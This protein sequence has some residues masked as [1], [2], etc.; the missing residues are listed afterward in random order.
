MLRRFNLSVYS[1]KQCV[2]VRNLTFA[3][4][5]VCRTGVSDDDFWRAAKTGGSRA[6]VLFGKR[7]RQVTPRTGVT[8]GRQPT[9]VLSRPCRRT[10]R[11]VALRRNF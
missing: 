9:Q 7:P 11:V 1:L 2:T 5:I 4:R 3:T 8:F 6:G 10:Q